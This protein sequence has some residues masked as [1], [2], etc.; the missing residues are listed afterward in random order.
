M[1]AADFEIWQYAKSEGFIIVTADGDFFELATTLG[2][3]P[4]VVWLRRWNRP[5]SD[6]QALLRRES[7]RITEFVAD[8]DLAVLVLDRA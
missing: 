7:I 6:A 3:P 8:P 1:N 5:T 2:P 4:K